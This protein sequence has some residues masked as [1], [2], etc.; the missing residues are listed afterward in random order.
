MSYHPAPAAVNP[1]DENFGSN[2]K[3]N[4]LLARVLQAAVRAA[5]AR[6]ESS[7]LQRHAPKVAF[8]NNNAITRLRHLVAGPGF[9]TASRIHT[10]V[11][12][13][14]KIVGLRRSSQ[15]RQIPKRTLP[16]PLPERSRRSS[17]R[18]STSSSPKTSSPRSTTPSRSTP[19]RTA[20]TINLT[21]EVQQHLGGGKVRAVALGSTDGLRRGMD[22]RRHRRARHRPGR[23]GNARPRLQPARRADRQSRPGARRPSA[24]RSTASRRNSSI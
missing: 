13:P 11:G 7:Q 15:Q 10:I 5:G 20:Q 6:C 23:Q 19:S 22:V 8:G 16:C 2:S 24:G 18:P 4:A 17:A 14:G 9:A 3:A 1:R 21:G 12:P